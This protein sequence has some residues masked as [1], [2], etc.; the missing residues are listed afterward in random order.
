MPNEVRAK[1]KEGPMLDEAHWF[2]F[3]A[4]QKLFPNVYFSFLER[5][6]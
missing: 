2:E 1:G 3:N 4:E 6:H 5:S